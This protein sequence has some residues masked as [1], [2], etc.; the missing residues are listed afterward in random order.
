MMLLSGLLIATF[1]ASVVNAA[2]IV[3]GDDLLLF[4]I[5]WRDGYCYLPVEDVRIVDV[6]QFNYDQH[7]L[8]QMQDHSAFQSCDFAGAVLKG[9]MGAGR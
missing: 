6:L 9:D 8:Y 3:V 2:T 7:N 5:G 1:G 4:N